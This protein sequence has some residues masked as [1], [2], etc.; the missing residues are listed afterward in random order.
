MSK[1]MQKM[2]NLKKNYEVLSMSLQNE[3]RE[4]KI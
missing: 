3:E 1:S 2:S 4:E